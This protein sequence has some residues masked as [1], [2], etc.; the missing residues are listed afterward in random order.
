MP[1]CCFLSETSRMLEIHR[2]LRDRG[3]PVR[4]ATHGGPHE[5]ALRDA[6]VAYDRIGPAMS[7]ERC[8]R[9]VQSVPGIG[10][11]DQSVWSD[12]ELRAYTAAEAAYFRAHDVRVAVT[13]WTLTALLST[14]LVGIP[15][16]T[17]HAGS[18]LPPLME[19]GLLPAPTRPVGLPLERWLPQRLRRLLFNAGVQRMTH[20]TAGFNRV[21]A[22]LGVEGV[23][24]LAALLV[25]DLSLVT[26]VPEVL[27]LARSDV[28]GWRPRK[29]RHYR[30]GT[31]LRYTGPLFAH[32]AI[33]TPADVDEFLRRPG[34]VVYVAVTSSS[35]GLVREI[36][37]ALRPL[38]VRILVAAT[39]HDLADLAD[40]QVHV[41]GVLP[42]HEIMPR[43]ALA[44]TAA[45]HGSV[46]TALAS[47]TPLIG[48]PLQP[49][50]DAN[51][52]LAERTGAARCVPLAQAGGPVLTRTARE[53]LADPRARAAAARM[54]EVFAQ[55]DGAAG[56][57]EAICELLDEVRGA[58]AVSA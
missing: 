22:E 57:A 33:P 35:V 23:P 11:V 55:V 39:V 28:D 45:G 37:G 46:Q 1:N 4:V 9:L 5:Q 24:G 8:E 36:V 47:G 31:R 2:A 48:V 26:D 29:P 12:E 38:G 7:R 49:E 52:A 3:A 41:A 44:V 18:F 58:A 10:P 14:R 30:S 51:I 17:E 21:A 19:R 32:L 54:R 50:Q 43:V 27:G 42:S 40:E 15:L 13:G 20:Y 56:A 25:S 34:P 6:G 16:V 53:L